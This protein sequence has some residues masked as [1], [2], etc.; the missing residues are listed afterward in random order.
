MSK[1][2]SQLLQRKTR[3][4]SDLPYCETTF[5]SIS[6][7]TFKNLSEINSLQSSKRYFFFPSGQMSN[8][9]FLM[10]VFTGYIFFQNSF[11]VTEYSNYR[12]TE[13]SV[14]P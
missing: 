2:S 9:S 10:S 5:H 3:A 12:N 7:N 8:K 6:K 13:G 4:Y 1:Q 11:Y 14:Y